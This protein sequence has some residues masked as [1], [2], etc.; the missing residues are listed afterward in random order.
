M[1]KMTAVPGNPASRPVRPVA[2]LVFSVALLV[3]TV[4]ACGKSDT[5]PRHEQPQDAAMA[6][7]AK[8]VAGDYAG[9]VAGMESCDSV[10]EFYR[11]QMVT[12]IKQHY[13]EEAAANGG[14]ARVEVARTVVV[15]DT[16]AANVFLDVTYGD[17]TTEE[18]VQPMVWDGRSWRLQ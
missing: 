3:A 4:A 18:I 6:Y 1:R 12:L 7:Y 5:T 14:L 10:P 13:R 8:L 11:E 2:G 16:V 9:F 17:S 15:Q